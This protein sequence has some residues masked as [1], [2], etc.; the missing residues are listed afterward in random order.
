MFA[1]FIKPAWRNGLAR[2]TS[3]PKVV[4]STPTVGAFFRGKQEDRKLT[5]GYPIE[6]LK[7]ELSFMKCLPFLPSLSS[8][9]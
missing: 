4:G 5:S 3:N 1:S 6:F 7:V 9:P 8:F 2:W